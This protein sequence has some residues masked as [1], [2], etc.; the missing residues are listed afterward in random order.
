MGITFFTSKAKH[1]KTKEFNTQREFKRFYYY[2]NG[3]SS[4]Q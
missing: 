4:Y 3:A 1:N 2:R